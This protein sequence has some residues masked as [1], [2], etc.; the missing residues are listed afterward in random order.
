VDEEVSREKNDETDGLNLEV[1]SKD[2]HHH[3]TKFH[4]IRLII[5][6][7]ILLTDRQTDRTNERTNERQTNSS[8]DITPPWQ[9]I[10]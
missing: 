7:V 2:Q 5:F 6:A 10:S 4:E 8:D 3:N 1:D 9:V